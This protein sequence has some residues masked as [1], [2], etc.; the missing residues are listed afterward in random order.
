MSCAD[1]VYCTLE[2]LTAKSLLRS[3][4]ACCR[5][6]QYKNLS[7]PELGACAILEISRCWPASIINLPFL[8]PPGFESYSR[9]L[10][11]LS[12][13]FS[14]IRQAVW[15]QGEYAIKVPMESLVPDLSK[16]TKAERIEEMGLMHVWLSGLKALPDTKSYF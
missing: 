11:T 7:H 15:R 13:T 16:I 3:L 9:W 6:S 2:Q 1:M 8:Q 4:L 12:V 5:V 14:A 10:V